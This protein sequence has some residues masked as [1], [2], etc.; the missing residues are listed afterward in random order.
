MDED[1]ATIEYLE[2]EIARTL[3]EMIDT[4][5]RSYKELIRLRNDVQEY[6]RH[7]GR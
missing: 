6:K 7:V 1:E 2:R 3:N 5:N 4:T